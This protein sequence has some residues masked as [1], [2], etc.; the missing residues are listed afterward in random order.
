MQLLAFLYVRIFCPVERE[1]SNSFLPRSAGVMLFSSQISQRTVQ[2]MSAKAW[3]LASKLSHACLLL[4]NSSIDCF[5]FPSAECT[6]SCCG[7]ILSNWELCWVGWQMFCLLTEIPND[8]AASDV[9]RDPRTAFWVTVLIGELFQMAFV[10][11][12]KKNTTYGICEWSCYKW[13]GQGAAIKG[14]II[15]TIKQLCSTCLL[16]MATWLW[17]WFGPARRLWAMEEW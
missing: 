7:E 8:V 5:L 9:T 6:N 12:E 4:L 16:P 17:E 11:Q 13:G 10:G 2:S 14:R 1:G 3:E 15:T